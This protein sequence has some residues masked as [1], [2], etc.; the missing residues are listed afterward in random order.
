MFCNARARNIATKRDAVRV[1]IPVQYSNPYVCVCVCVPHT[2]ADPHITMPALAPGLRVGDVQPASGAASRRARFFTGR[3]FARNVKESSSS[4]TMPVAASSAS[5]SSNA[6]DALV[7]DML[8][9]LTAACAGGKND[10]NKA[11]ARLYAS[12]AVLLDRSTRAKNVVV[13]GSEAIG[14]YTQSAKEFANGTFELV[15]V[16]SSERVS[17]V[18]SVCAVYRCSSTIGETDCL[19][20][21]RFCSGKITHDARGLTLNGSINE[22]RNRT[23]VSNAEGADAVALMAIQRLVEL[24]PDHEAVADAAEAGALEAMVEALNERCVA[25]TANA[26]IVYALLPCMINLSSGADA[27]GLQRSKALVRLDAIRALN[28]VLKTCQTLADR[29]GELAPVAGGSRPADDVGLAC[30]LAIRCVWALQHLCRRSSASLWLPKLEDAGTLRLVYE[31]VQRSQMRTLTLLTRVAF[32]SA[33]YGCALGSDAI[34]ASSE[35]RR[36]ELLPVVCGLVCTRP[37]TAREPLPDPGCE[38]H[39]AAALA[40]GD[41]VRSPATVL[42]AVRCGAL[43]GLAAAMERYPRSVSLQVNACWAVR[44]IWEHAS[45]DDGSRGV[46]AERE[47]EMHLRCS[48]AVIAA[49]TTT[50]AHDRVRAQ[51]RNKREEE[52][53][54]AARAMRT[55]ALK[56]RAQKDME[57]AK[58]TAA[59]PEPDDE[60]NAKQATANDRAGLRNCGPLTSL[61]RDAARFYVFA[62]TTP[63]PNA[64]ELEA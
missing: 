45:V 22:L 24:M 16:S 8:E 33:D 32:L 23:R 59:S 50:E 29:E 37:D 57:H 10:S 12:D 55:A 7:A 35:A 40:V 53:L 5:S 43:I 13:V 42:L 2:H 63:A 34:S 28:G 6:D 61:I 25:T 46:I 52:C 36:L 54:H 60:P 49:L 14:R 64:V 30:D 48:G 51:L 1:H 4:T 18:R 20:S 58:E 44:Q 15:R 56:L 41:A 39:E 17:G 38:L 21:L 11:I 62:S 47:A 27:A 26:K 9:V 3:F 31:L 19:G